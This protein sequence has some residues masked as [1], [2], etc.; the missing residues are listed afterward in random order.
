MCR[1]CIGTVVRLIHGTRCPPLHL[2]CCPCCRMSAPW[3]PIG[4]NQHCRDGHP[5]SYVVLAGALDSE[6]LNKQLQKAGEDLYHAPGL[7]S[8]SSLASAACCRPALTSASDSAG[9]VQMDCGPGDLCGL[10]GILSNGQRPVGTERGDGAGAPQPESRLRASACKVPNHR[11]L[12]CDLLRPSQRHDV[13]I[14]ALHG[15]SYKSC[16]PSHKLI[17]FIWR[18][19][20]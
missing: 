5:D 6:Q 10:D 7:S 8:K 16:A 11:P 15:I 13:D 2:T 20:S 1:R 9:P 14:M 12:S 19:P 17:A 3:R 4:L 18:R